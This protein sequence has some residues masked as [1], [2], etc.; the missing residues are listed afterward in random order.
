[1]LFAERVASV[2]AAE[3]VEFILIEVLTREEAVLA[4]G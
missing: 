2:A 3:G 1:L 4:L